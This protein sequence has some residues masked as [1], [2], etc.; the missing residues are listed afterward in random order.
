P[1]GP[2]GFGNGPRTVH[3]QI[4]ATTLAT[5][6]DRIRLRQSDT[7][8]GGHDTGAYGSAGMFVAGKATHAAAVQL[9]T[10][11]ERPAA[12]A[13]FCDVGSCTLESEA[14]VSGV[15][16]MSF[17]ELAKLARE[18]GQPFAGAGN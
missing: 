3:R 9:A 12:G 7:A 15:R 16:R 17:A 2:A 1:A 6:V 10:E 14:V 8:H 5:T 18:R 11:L 4:A 13:W